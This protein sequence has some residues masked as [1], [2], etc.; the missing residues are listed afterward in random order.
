MNLGFLE[1]KFKYSHILNCRIWQINN[2][3]KTAE[4]FT[5]NKRKMSLQAIMNSSV[6]CSPQDLIFRISSDSIITLGI[7][8]LRS[9]QIILLLLNL[10]AYVRSV[11]NK[12]CICCCA[13]VAF[14]YIQ[15]IFFNYIPYISNGIKSCC[16]IVA[17][18]ASSCIL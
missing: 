15:E 8:A 14:V 12:R 1:V 3:T 7:L 18:E 9:I 13:I 5:S 2:L 17:S 6:I 4:E 16:L 10:R 11:W